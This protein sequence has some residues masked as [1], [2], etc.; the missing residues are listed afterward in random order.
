M[1]REQLIQDLI[2]DEG[3]R[4]EPYTD[5][6][7][8]LTIGIGRNLD[9]NGI[10]KAEAMFLL[11]NDIEMVETELDAKMDWWRGLPD[12][13]QRALCNM[14]FNMGHPRISH[15]KKMLSSLK[16]RNFE[17]AAAHALDSKWADQVGQ[18]ADRIATLFRNA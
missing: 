18:R 7:G 9:D 17:G 3:M 12:D 6:V 5:T 15:F 1:D 4:T 11:A 10:S 2:L 16:S 13:A 14:T 8:K